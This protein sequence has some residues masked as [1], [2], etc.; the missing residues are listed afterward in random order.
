MS[1][2]TK[3]KAGYAVLLSFWGAVL[4]ILSDAVYGGYL[5]KLQQYAWAAPVYQWLEIHIGYSLAD[6]GFFTLY[7]SL[8]LA[9]AGCLLGLAVLW[10][11]SF[12]F[13]LLGLISTIL[14]GASLW[15]AAPSWFLTGCG[16]AM[17]LLSPH[18]HSIWDRVWALCL[19]LLPL[20]AL[21]I[22]TRVSKLPKPTAKTP[23][24]L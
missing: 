13:K 21:Y 1:A 15:Y 16:M 10:Q 22:Y 7:L 6:F 4:V 17:L 8:T 20:T 12:G 23:N 19:L 18:T 5:L 9:L 11:G 14:A 2:I 24:D 3:R